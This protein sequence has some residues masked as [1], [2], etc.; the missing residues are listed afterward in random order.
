MPPN[1]ASGDMEAGTDERS[2]VATATASCVMLAPCL[3]GV[4]TSAAR[5]ELLGWTEKTNSIVPRTPSGLSG[6][7]V[8]V[9]MNACESHDGRTSGL[10]SVFRAGRRAQVSVLNGVSDWSE[11]R[12]RLDHTT[13]RLIK[14]S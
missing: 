8:S 12:P 1:Q 4:V 5:D 14:S 10:T 2:L 6:T 11:E 3:W 9:F 13:Y 7:R